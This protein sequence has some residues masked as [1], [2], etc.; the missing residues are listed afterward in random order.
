MTEKEVKKMVIKNIIKLII[1]VILL[2]ISYFYVQKNPVE[3][4]AIYSWF[5]TLFQRSNVLIHKIFWEKAD[6]LNKKY[7]LEKYYKELLKMSENKKC[8]D[9]TILKEINKNYSDLKKEHLDTLQKNYPKYVRSAY[10]YDKI[11]KSCE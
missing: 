4:I 3:K 2:T 7:T 1:W 11:V 6:L 10:K 8:V 9:V 5:E